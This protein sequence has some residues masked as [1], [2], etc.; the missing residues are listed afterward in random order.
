MLINVKLE[1]NKDRDYD[2]LIEKDILLE[3]INYK[4]DF[5]IIYNDFFQRI[6]VK[7]DSGKKIIFNYPLILDFTKTDKYT[8]Q[9]FLENSQNF[10]DIKFSKD[11]A[12]L[13][14]TTDNYI[15]TCTVNKTHFDGIQTGYYFPYYSNKYLNDTIIFK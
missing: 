8:I 2:F 12:P 1:D 15:K 7:P 13:E 9:F 4:Y 3:N 6:S 10:N 11:S 14:C 5:K